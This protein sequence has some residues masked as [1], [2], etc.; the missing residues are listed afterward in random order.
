MES[1]IKIGDRVSLH[2]DEPSAIGYNGIVCK[3]SMEWQK[4]GERLLYCES[5]YGSAR[6]WAREKNLRKQHNTHA[7]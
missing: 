4:N 6:I 5:I 2:F 7:S 3:V 1:Q